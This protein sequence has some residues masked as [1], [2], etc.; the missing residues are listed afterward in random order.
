MDPWNNNEFW[1]S[2][3]TNYL[4]LFVEMTQ[5]LI[6]AEHFIFYLKYHAANIRA[7]IVL[8]ITPGDND[9]QYN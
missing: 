4:V 2:S 5:G 7:T 8:V 3:W 6:G 9:Q 1:I